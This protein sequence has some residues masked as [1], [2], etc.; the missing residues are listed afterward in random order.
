MEAEP[1]ATTLGCEFEPR[2]SLRYQRDVSGIEDKGISLYG[3]GISIRDIYNQLKAHYRIDLSEEIVSKITDRILPESKE[4]QSRPLNTVHPFIFI[5]VI[6]YKVCEDGRILSH[7]VCI[8]LGGYK[9]I[10]SITVD[11]NET[12]KFGLEMLNDLKN[13]GV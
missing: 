1:N 7:T 6:Q 3:K 4:W 2:L 11:T 8:A 9:D 13:C 12:S 5:D 10:L